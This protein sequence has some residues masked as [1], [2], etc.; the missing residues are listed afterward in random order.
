[1]IRIAGIGVCQLNDVA[2]KR[3]CKNPILIGLPSFLQELETFHDT[4]MASLLINAVDC[5]AFFLFLYIFVAF[6]D[7]IR[8]RGLSYPPGPPSRPIIGNLLD[9]PKEASWIAYADMSKKYGKGI[10]IAAPPFQHS[11]SPSKV[12]FFAF[13]ILGT[14]WSC[15]VRMR[16]SRIYSTSVV[17]LTQIGPCCQLWKCALGGSYCHPIF[18]SV[19][20][21]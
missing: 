21:M 12:T 6:R 5:L 11:Y 3:G 16:P 19:D 9:V 7:H 17:K 8:Y 18:H 15:C 20:D 2:Q 4:V 1:V 10:I 13:A 14:S